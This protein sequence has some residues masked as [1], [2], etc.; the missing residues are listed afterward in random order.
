MIATSGIK[1]LAS[2]VGGI[3]MNPRTAGTRIS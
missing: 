2:I 3:I 1:I